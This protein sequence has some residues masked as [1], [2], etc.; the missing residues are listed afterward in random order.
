MERAGTYRELLFRRTVVRIHG[1]PLKENEERSYEKKHSF[2][3]LSTRKHYPG[4]HSIAII[5][6]GAE[7]DKLDFSLEK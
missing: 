7:R 3:D 1:S 5:V 6:N 2:K 4:I